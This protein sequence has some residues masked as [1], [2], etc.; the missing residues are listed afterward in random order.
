MDLD[1]QKSAIEGEGH[2]SKDKVDE[3]NRTNNPPEFVRNFV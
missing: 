2:L 1:D 3:R